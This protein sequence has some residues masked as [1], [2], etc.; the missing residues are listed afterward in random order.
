MKQAAL[1]IFIIGM[2]LLVG[3]QIG[4]IFSGNGSHAYQ[5]DNAFIEAPHEM[6]WAD[7]HLYDDFEAHVSNHFLGMKVDSNFTAFDYKGNPVILSTLANKN[8]IFARYS[9]S[10]CR[11]CIET[12]L[13]ALKSKAEI[14]KTAHII[15]II[16]GISPRDLFVS[17]AEFGP[18]FSLLAAEQL[19]IDFNSAETPVVFTVENQKINKHF[20]CRFADAERTHNYIS[21][22]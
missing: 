9:N 19:P 8:T 5:P 16:K 15:L 22:L 7:A 1:Y 6:L 18:F 17:E 4:R 20:T 10:G 13:T 3:F 12:L 2:I 21:E 14:S 11:P